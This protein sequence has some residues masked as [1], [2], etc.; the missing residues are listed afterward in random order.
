MVF[1]QLKQVEAMPCTGYSSCTWIIARFLHNT[2]CASVDLLCAGF[3]EQVLNRNQLIGLMAQGF[4][5]DLSHE[6]EVL[7]LPAPSKQ[8][9]VRT[10]TAWHTCGPAVAAAGS[11]NTCVLGLGCTQWFSTSVTG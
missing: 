3:W 9:L 4:Q 11:V 6:G 10:T 8:L 7:P 5:R 1:L 2:C